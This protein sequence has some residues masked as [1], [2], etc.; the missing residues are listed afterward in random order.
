MPARTPLD[1]IQYLGDTVELPLPTYPIGTKLNVH[2]LTSENKRYYF[3]K[4][5]REIIRD[6]RAILAKLQHDGYLTEM[7]G[8][9]MLECNKAQIR[10]KLD[11][12]R[13]ADVVEIAGHCPNGMHV[14]GTI[15]NQCYLVNGQ[16]HSGVDYEHYLL[17]RRTDAGNKIV[18]IHPYPLIR[19]CYLK[20]LV[21]P[22][23]PST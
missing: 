9:K 22:S 18:Y 14:T 8:K 5:V 23:L 19:G 15:S 2:R 21:I 20:E 12:M 6:T 10:A 1:Q 13:L 4:A 3:R 17:F 7:V 16:C 11:M